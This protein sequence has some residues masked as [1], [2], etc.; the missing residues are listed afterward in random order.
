MVTGH[1]TSTRV[2]RAM[3]KELFSA[4]QKAYIVSLYRP[5]N[6]AHSFSALAL[7]FS[8]PGRSRTVQRWYNQYNGTIGSLLHKKGQGRPRILSRSQV[9]RYVLQ[10]IRRKN[11]SHTAIHYTDLISGIHSSTRK[12]PSLRTIQRYGKEDVEVRAKRTKKISIDEC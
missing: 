9:S 10:P 4:K 3:V 12:K 7:R 6:R 11:R 1:V 8:V 2:I 5:R